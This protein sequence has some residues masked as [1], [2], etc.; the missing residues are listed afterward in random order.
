[1]GRIEEFIEEI[2][3]NFSSL[4]NP[5]ESC[6]KEFLLMSLLRMVMKEINCQNSLTIDLNQHATLFKFGQH[7]SVL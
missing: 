6:A 7:S 3:K 5:L 4:L 2:A 1:M